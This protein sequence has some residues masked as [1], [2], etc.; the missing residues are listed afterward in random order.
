MARRTLEEIYGVNTTQQDT[1]D[2]SSMQIQ[3]QPKRR[4]L[5]EIYG[6][7]KPT[8]SVS[9]TAPPTTVKVPF[10]DTG[11]GPANNTFMANLGTSAKEI[12]VDPFTS[13]FSNIDYGNQN[14]ASNALQ[15][16]G[17]VA[18]GAVDVIGK[19]LLGAAKLVTPKP[20]EEAVGGA[21]GAISQGVS[22]AIPEETKQALVSWAEQHPEAAA[23]LGAVVDIASIIPVGKAA[24]VTKSALKT[25]AGVLAKAE[26]AVQRIAQPSKPEL[27]NS[28]QAIRGLE[29]IPTEKIK[30]YSQLRE[31]LQAQNTTD[32]AKV[33]SEIS[34]DTTKYRLP[35]F[36]IEKEGMKFNP[37]KDALV[38]LRELAEKTTDTSL[39]SKVRQF[40]IKVNTGK[41]VQN[42]VNE[43][44]K[45]VGSKMNAFK[46]NGEL[47][48]RTN[49]LKAENTRASLKD[50][51]RTGMSPEVAALDKA[52]SD[53]IV[54]TSRMDNIANA[55]QREINRSPNLNIFQKAVGATERVADL[56]TGRVFS[57]ILRELRNSNRLSAVEIEKELAK[58]LALVR[59]I[60]STKDVNRIKELLKAAKLFTAGQVVNQVNQPEQPQ[61]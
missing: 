49:A 26:Q 14:L 58:N 45:L 18:G 21:V 32:L 15:T 2:V 16:A 8:I 51:A 43:L 47:L 38:G 3:N 50:I 39:M 42:D 37:V 20:V 61:Q 19:G 30:T 11:A 59:E 33:T 29:T 25:E 53:R 10:P 55:V 52:I 12:L 57:S 6:I 28:A 5:E 40:E 35:D 1:A 13:R 34:K 48:K 17:A 7:Q 44:A 36:Q 27:F 4:S 46:Q 41:M 60:N 9:Q 23:N 54:F 56:F 24:T 31:S 22:S